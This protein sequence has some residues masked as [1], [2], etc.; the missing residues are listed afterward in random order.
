MCLI[1][2]FTH[3]VDSQKPTRIVLL[4]LHNMPVQEIYEELVQQDVVP[5][6]LKPMRIRNSKFLEHNNFILYFK[7]GTMTTAK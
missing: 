5:D 7:K 1:P 3:Q 2:H 4:G 6:D